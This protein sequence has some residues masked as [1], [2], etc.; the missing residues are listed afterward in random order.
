[1]KKYRSIQSKIGALREAVCTRDFP[2]AG[3]YFWDLAKNE[4]LLSRQFKEIKF[5]T[6]TSLPQAEPTPL[7]SALSTA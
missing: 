2:K 4:K 6:P 5:I 3:R 7:F 1:M